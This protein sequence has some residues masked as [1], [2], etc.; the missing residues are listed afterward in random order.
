MGNKL[1][2]RQFMRTIEVGGVAV[3]LAGCLDLD[4]EDDLT[5]P[6]DSTGENR[7]TTTQ[8]TQQTPMQET[9]RPE[10]D[11]HGPM[12]TGRFKVTIND[13]AVAGWRSVTIPGMSV[14]S[15]EYRE[16][17][18]ADYEKK[19]WG[20]VTYEDLE[21]ERGFDPSA[22]ELHDWTKDIE[23][24]NAD[25]GRKEI[26]VVLQDEEGEAVI[27]WEFQKAWITEYDP[28]D[29]DASADG[30]VATE[31]ITVEFDKMIRKKV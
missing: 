25:S 7:P 20:E 4:L 8:Q 23:A 13:V 2:R 1:N 17:D 30:E 18:D 16:G 24:G 6:T 27:R 22:T 5:E 19:V 28:P 29:L 15:G 9:E 10:A 26:A 14:E 3:T 21:M 11:R 12:R 31:S